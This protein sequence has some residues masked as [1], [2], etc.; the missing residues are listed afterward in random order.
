MKSSDI[1]LQL[2]KAEIV[3]LDPLLKQIDGPGRATWTILPDSPGVYAVC[4]PGWEASSFAADA[5][6]ARH[7]TPTLA[8]SS[9]SGLVSSL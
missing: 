5:G 4:L 1:E 6:R 3:S 7:A 8:S 9:T 2:G